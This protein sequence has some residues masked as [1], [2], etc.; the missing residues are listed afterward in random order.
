MADKNQSS[1]KDFEIFRAEREKD[2]LRWLIISSS[3]FLIIVF[4]S[5]F[6]GQNIFQIEIIS[7]RNFFILSVGNLLFLGFVFIFWKR[8]YLS[9][10]PKYLF[11]IYYP[12][13]IAAW[14]YLTDPE[15]ANTISSGF[16]IIAAIIGGM[17]YDVKVCVVSSLIGSVAYGAVLLY[18]SFAGTP[19]SIYEIFINYIFFLLGIIS[20]GFASWRTR[21]F[22]TELIEK[23]KELMEKGL[24]LEETKK[25]LEIRVSARTRELEEVAQ[26]LDEKVKVRTLELENRVKE[27]ERFYKITIGREL[28]MLELKKEIARLKK[29]LSKKKK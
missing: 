22:L 17:F 15:Y 19:V 12:L 4:F 18:Y 13:L 6:V 5:G 16:L 20:V 1:L 28:K 7:W 29:E 21:R 2:L 11:A 26:G 10:L 23:R 14:I 9:W 25:T 27:L 24:E 3:I 8:K